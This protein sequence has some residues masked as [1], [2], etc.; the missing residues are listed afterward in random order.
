MDFT[1]ND[2]QQMI[3]DTVRSFVERELY[4]HEDL[5]DRLDD[6]PEEIAQQIQRAAITFGVLLPTYAWSAEFWK[7]AA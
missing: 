3:V 5:V 7:L 2:E 1:L 6:V 4:P